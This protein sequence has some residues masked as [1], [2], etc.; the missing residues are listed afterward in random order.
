MTRATVVLRALSRLKRD[1]NVLH[2]RHLEYD[3]D[4]EDDDK[5]EGDGFV[6]HDYAFLQDEVVEDE[7]S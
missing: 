1:F 4:V 2:L 5:K 3:H 6:D 7:S